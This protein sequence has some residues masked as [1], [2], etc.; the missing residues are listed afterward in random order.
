M[1]RQIEM[2]VF[3]TYLEDECTI[4]FSFRFIKDKVNIGEVIIHTC[5]GEIM[6]KKKKLQT[7]AYCRKF[8]I[9]EEYLPIT[10]AKLMEFL[11]MIGVQR[12]NFVKNKKADQLAS[13]YLTI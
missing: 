1:E 12:F 7:I 10:V 8:S 3:P 4:I 13:S 2:K 6:K 5:M 9:M 11:H